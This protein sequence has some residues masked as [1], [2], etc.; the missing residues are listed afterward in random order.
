[1]IKNQSFVGL[2]VDDR[3]G[4]ARSVSS[5]LDN[6][7]TGR[8]CLMQTFWNS[9]LP[10]KLAT[11]AWTVTCGYFQFISTLSTVAATHPH[12]QLH[13]SHCACPQSSL[14]TICGSHVGQNRPC[15]PTIRDLCSDHWFLLLIIQ[16]QTKRQQPLL[17]H[18]SPLLQVPS[19]LTD[20]TSRGLKGPPPLS[21]PLHFFHFSLFGSQTL[22][23]RTFK[24][25]AHIGDNR[26]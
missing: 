3:L 19:P 7:Y 10:G 12:S 5:Y 14:H 17:S 24:I 18:L 26:D 11:S 4:S 2:W 6:N 25:T 9:G 1:M 21:L 20:V 22:K 8:I 15:P 16:M 23:T 13:G